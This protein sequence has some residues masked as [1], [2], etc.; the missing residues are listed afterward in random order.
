M[1]RIL[2][3]SPKL[4]DYGISLDSPI[5]CKVITLRTFASHICMSLSLQENMFKLNA[6]N[7]PLNNKIPLSSRPCDPKYSKYKSETKNFPWTTQL[8]FIILQ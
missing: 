4:L 2:N 1:V 8:W 3:S 5:H 7:I 6:F